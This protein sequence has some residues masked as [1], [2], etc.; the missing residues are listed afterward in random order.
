MQTENERMNNNVSQI[1]VLENTNDIIKLRVAS[2]KI[3][4]RK[5]L[6]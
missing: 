2:D 3:L 6:D 4:V 5:G 1:T